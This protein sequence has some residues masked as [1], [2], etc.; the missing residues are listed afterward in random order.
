MNYWLLL[1]ST[2]MNHECIPLS[3]FLFL[4]FLC[5]GSFLNVI[6]YRLV[7]DRSL[8]APRSACPHCNAII[9]WHDNIPLLSW[10][11]LRGKCRSC[12]QSISL[13]YPFIEL[14]TAIVLYA[15]Y[16]HVPHHYFLGYFLF[17]SA[18][19]VS[20]RTD[21]ET[22]LISRL[23]S[24]YAVP[25]GWIASWFDLLPITVGESILGS[26]FG[27]GLF[28]SIGTLFYRI[29][30]KQGLGEGDM[31]LLALIGACTGIIGCWATMLIGSVIGSIVGILLMVGTQYTRNTRIPFGPFLVLGAIC[32]IL[33]Q[34]QILMLL[35]GNQWLAT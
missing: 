2:H 7:H 19:M 33:W 15:T 9:A 4:I 11:L 14:A 16:V 22:M 29:T 30:G 13:L 3:I 1:G 8:W 35:M 24:L 23:V 28:W 6:A 20:V 12:G 34:Q 26:L 10:A 18:L 31:E 25:V 5:W 21:L 32:Y 17:T 27:Y